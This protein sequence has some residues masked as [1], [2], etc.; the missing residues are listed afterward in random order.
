MLGQEQIMSNQCPRKNLVLS[1]ASGP[2]VL[3]PDFEVFVNS[4]RNIRNA[5]LV[6]ITH[7]MDQSARQ[8]LS[9]NGAIVVDVVAGE[10]YYI[11]RDRHKHFYDYLCKHGYQYENVLISD[12]RDVVFQDDPF[13][14]FKNY[15]LEFTYD[16]SVD[17]VKESVSHKVVLTAEG[18]KRK[19]SGFA[20]IEH[21]EFQK[22][23]PPLY[24]HEDN[25]QSVC[26]AGIFLG[27]STAIKEFE[28]LMFMVS[29]K[30]IGR[31]TDQAALNYIVGMIQDDKSFVIS[32]PQSD[33]LCLTGEGVKMG[34][35]KP[36]LSQGKL[37]NELNQLYYMIHQWD[38]LDSLR[39][40]ILSQYG[41]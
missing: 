41:S 39:E 26:N 13:V 37:Y 32:H 19:E 21:F 27:T 10:N 33:N 4:F 36:I 38:R 31:C 34:S 22:D 29:M 7:E 5:D 17:C 16:F 40:E 20:C 3:K 2:M 23:V 25:T 30:T 28:L 15:T 8:K 14:W 1:Y 24:F 9:D 6:F 11:Y 18:F 12:S 35:V